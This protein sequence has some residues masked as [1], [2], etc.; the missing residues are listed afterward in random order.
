M[1]PVCEFFFFA[2][3]DHAEEVAIRS[4]KMQNNLCQCKFL[5]NQFC[6]S[7]LEVDYLAPRLLC[8]QRKIIGK[9]KFTQ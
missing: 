8:A 6:N 7:Y 1:P 3:S 5:M 9:P 2:I 4:I